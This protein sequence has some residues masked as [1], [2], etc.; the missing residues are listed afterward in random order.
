MQ[1]KTEKK[2]LAGGEATLNN[3]G[4]MTG[5][6]DLYSLDFI[7][8][9]SRSN[10]WVLDIGACYGVAVLPALAQGAKVIAAD[11]DE[12]HLTILNDRV[13]SKDKNR[14]RLLLG[15]L[16]DNINV[17]K[18]SLGAILCCRVLHLLKTDE[19]E[20][21]IAHMYEWLLSGGRLYLVNDTP[22]TRYSDKMLVEF[23]PIYQQKKRQGIEWPGYIPNLKFYLQSEFHHL[24]PEFITLTGVDELA[25]ACKRCGFKILKAGFIARNDYPPSLRNDGRENAGVIAIKS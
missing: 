1:S 9:A 21:S 7:E 25:D 22:Y 20:K 2:L 12:R 6:L 13:P 19:I 3:T 17:E 24:A 16:P 15:T 11:N 23:L 18:N 4:Y 14:L 10:E 5:G 8:Y